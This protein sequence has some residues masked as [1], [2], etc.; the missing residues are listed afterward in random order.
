M[1]FSFQYL[2][3]GI[4]LNVRPRINQEGR[5]ISMLIDATVSATV[6]GQDLRVIDPTSGI[7]LT[8][9]GDD[10]VL[11]SGSGVCAGTGRPW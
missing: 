8:E 7:T 1:A 2:P 5:E 11:I 3:T 9:V 10:R 6:P 4:L